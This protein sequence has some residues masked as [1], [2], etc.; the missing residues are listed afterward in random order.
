MHLNEL[1]EKYR[2]EE[3]ELKDKHF[4]VEGI[5]NYLLYL[6]TR[7]SGNVEV[8][9]DLMLTTDWKA[10][11]TKALRDHQMEQAHDPTKQWYPPGSIK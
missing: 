9:S 7:Y 4:Q 2:K 1:T 11:L 3:R 6:Q 5:L 10:R 8:D